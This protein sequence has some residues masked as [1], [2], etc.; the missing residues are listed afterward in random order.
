MIASKGLL[1]W[2]AVI[3]ILNVGQWAY[4]ILKVKP[5]ENPIPLHYTTTFGID[6]IGPWYS[7]FLL[8]L[9]GTIMFI[10]NLALTSVTIEHQRV[11]AYMITAISVLTQITLMAAAVLIFRTL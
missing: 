9:S 8:P 4:C 10:L 5:Q 6:R 2:L 7:A 11:A 1:V 3:V